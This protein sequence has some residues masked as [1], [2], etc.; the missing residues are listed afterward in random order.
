MAFV[1]VVVAFVV[2]VGIVAEVAV[3]VVVAVAVEEPF[4]VLFGVK[5]FEE[6][7]Q[8]R[9]ESGPRGRENG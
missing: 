3:V 2:V 7:V 9:G 4:V 5:S 8:W 6:V 1:V